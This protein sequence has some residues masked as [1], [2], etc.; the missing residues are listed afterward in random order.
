MAQVGVT[1]QHNDAARSGANLGEKILTTSNV[2]PSNFG[3]LFSRDVDGYVYAQPLYLPDITVAGKGTHNVVYVATEHN[4]VYAFDAEIAAQAAPLWKVNLGAP[5]PSGDICQGIA[6][7]SLCPY[8]DI[9]PEIGITSTPVIDAGSGTLYV[10]AKTKTASGYHFTLHALDVTSGA[11]KFGGPVTIEATVKGSGADSN[12]GTIQF[13]ALHQNNRP[14]LLLLNGVVYV[15]F[16]AVGDIPPFHGWVMGYNASTLQQTAVFN[17]SPD[18]EDAGIWA[19]GQGLAGEG[20]NVFLATGNGTFDAASGGRDLGSS[21]VR[22]DASQG[23]ALGDYF[24]P[25]NQGYLTSNDLDVGGGGVVLLPGMNDLVGVGKDGMLRLVDKGQMGKY[26]AAFDNA[27]QE[28]HVAS[29]FMGAPVVW[30]GQ[31][32]A[33]LY[34]WGPG[35]PLREYTFSGG[36]L[37]TAA[38]SESTMRVPSGTSNSVPLSI[39]A[40]DTAPGS[41]IVWAAAPYSGDATAESV[42]GVVRAFDAADVSRELWDSKQNPQR[43]ELGA[44]VKFTPPTVANGRVYVPTSSGKLA[45]YG[46]TSGDFTVNAEPGVITQAG[47]TT[48]KII[49]QANGLTSPLSLSC[50]DLP[51]GTSCTFSPASLPAGSD[52]MQSTLTVN[53]SSAALNSPHS[54]RKLLLASWLWLGLCGGIAPLGLR[55]KRVWSVLA[56]GVGCA[57]LLLALACG[58]G[59]SQSPAPPPAALGALPNG[60]FHVVAVSGGIAHRSKVTLSQ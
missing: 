34:L 54:R 28:F 39:S 42:P 29:I 48:V 14:G 19:G 50:A 58:G 23:L 5:V 55:R 2:N 21:F 3:K 13:N 44:F 53:V 7:S 38:H 46:L 60:S 57:I 41:G 37:V 12:G 16:G 31:S 52:P 47:T 59:A 33:A 22:L 56:L 9:A 8:T 15:A 27:I 45:V 18:G 35:E 40:N 24:T 43:D 6:G 51:A 17:S 20:N 26:N 1:T 36:Q 25:N 4:S 30:K 49:P 10:V 11:E 32:G